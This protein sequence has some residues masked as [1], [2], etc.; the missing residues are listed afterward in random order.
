MLLNLAKHDSQLVAAFHHYGDTLFQPWF[1]A[2]LFAQ[3]DKINQVFF[4][5]SVMHHYHKN[6][7][8]LAEMHE[9]AA[10]S[11]PRRDLLILENFVLT[12]QKEII[13]LNRSNNGRRLT[14]NQTCISINVLLMIFLLSISFSMPLYQTAILSSGLFVLTILN[15]ILITH[16]STP[17]LNRTIN[18]YQLQQNQR[19]LQTLAQ[20]S[21]TSANL[22]EKNFML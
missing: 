2:C 10:Q 19:R 14:T 20:E 12:L 1:F 4:V 7:C 5:N 22:T 11:L 9:L 13:H 6:L 3:A 17:K 15:A 18:H 8:K 16:G 21:Q